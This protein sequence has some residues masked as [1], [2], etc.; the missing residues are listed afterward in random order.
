MVVSEPVVAVIGI[1]FTRAG[2][3]IGGGVDIELPFN[4]AV[5]DS[6]PDVTVTENTLFLVL[7]I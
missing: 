6:V 7:G 4:F 5:S 1:E 2:C 3:F